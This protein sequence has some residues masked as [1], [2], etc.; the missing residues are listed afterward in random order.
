MELSDTLI[1]SHRAAAVTHA[2]CFVARLVSVL[3]IVASIGCGVGATPAS[4]SATPTPALQTA[5]NPAE[6]AA[7]PKEATAKPA[8]P[9]PSPA[10]PVASGKAPAQLQKVR[11]G[12][13]VGIA[14]SWAYIAK[15]KGIFQEE[16]LDVEVI[17]FKSAPDLFPAL[18]TGDIDAGVTAPSA[19]LYNAIIRGVP[20]R[21][22][23]G[24]ART[25]PGFRYKAWVVRKDLKDSIKSYAD[26][27]GRNIAI[28]G[29]GGGGT[30]EYT[31]YQALGRVGLSYQDV[32]TQNLAY[33][34]INPAMAGKAIDVAIQM[35]PFLTQGIDQGTFDSWMDVADV[36]AEGNQSSVLMYGA[37]FIEKKPDAAKRFA[38]GF[39]RGV[40]VYLDAFVKKQTPVSDVAPSIAKYTGITDISLLNR[41]GLVPLDPDGRVDTRGLAANIDWNLKMGYVKE[42]LDITEAV[43]NSFVDEAVRRLGKYE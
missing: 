26:L 14:Q 33:A 11:Y 32:N 31:L 13:L 37:Q 36:L 40:R 42:K 30:D 9:S 20:V 3:L 28:T 7:Q 12:Q 38:A 21:V 17:N 27:K 8:Q 25:I 6:S 4:K 34:D 24:T 15:E 22:V 18:A 43:D 39:I 23:A 29:M 35:D 16:G 5:S 1:R 10:R 19:G 41:L 2:R